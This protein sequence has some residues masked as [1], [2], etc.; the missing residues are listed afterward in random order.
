MDSTPL[1]TIITGVYKIMV[2]II[3]IKPTGTT[4]LDRIILSVWPWIRSKQNNQQY[5]PAMAKS[6]DGMVSMPRAAI[7]ETGNAPAMDGFLFT[8][9]SPT[10]ASANVRKTT[11][12][13]P[14]ALV[15]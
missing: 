3:V 8:I 7:A 4:N 12:A 13:Y 1:E 14:L 9:C 11:S 6:M 10:T 2:K 5:T 15:E